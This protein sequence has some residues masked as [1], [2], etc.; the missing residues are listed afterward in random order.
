MDLNMHAAAY[1]V[2]LLR[3]L[4]Q[5][6]LLTPLPATISE[7]LA[8]FTT[9]AVKDRRALDAGCRICQDNSKAGFADCGPV[10]GMG[11]SEV[12]RLMGGI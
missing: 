2:M 11:G 7:N 4:L 9:L 5:P 10:L 6:F 1:G 3:H 8:T 12:K